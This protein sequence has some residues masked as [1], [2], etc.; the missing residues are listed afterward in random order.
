M[1]AKDFFLT[2][3]LFSETIWLLLSLGILAHGA[4]LCFKEQWQ[5][6]KLGPWEQWQLTLFWAV[7]AGIA[8]GAAV[9]GVKAVLA[10]LLMNGFIWSV[11]VL[12]RGLKRETWE[13]NSAQPVLVGIFFILTFL[14]TGPSCG[15]QGRSGVSRVEAEMRQVATALEVYY[16]DNHV[17]P[18]S[19]GSLTTPVA[20]LSSL[21]L[22]CFKYPAGRDERELWV[23]HGP[24]A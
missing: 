15:G 12:L 23:L 7:L 3:H 1:V 19:L 13:K 9:G 21:P 10:L 16:I 4:Y 14:G 22:D 17:Y 11:I 2:K 6:V 20:H 5:K 18:P 24:S 8:F